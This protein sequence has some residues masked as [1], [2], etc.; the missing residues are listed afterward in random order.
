AAAAAATVCLIE[1][2]GSYGRAVGTGFLI[3]PSLVLTARHVVEILI[4][5]TAQHDEVR[6]WFDRKFLRN[7]KALNQGVHYGLADA[8]PLADDV[9]LDF[10][11]L[12]LDGEAGAGS[13]GWLRVP[14][15]PIVLTKGAPLIILQYPE[16]D[17]LKRALDM[18][19]IAGFSPDKRRILHQTN[20]RPG[21]SGAPCFDA[22]WKLVAMHCGVAAGAKGYNEAVIIEGIAARLRSDGILKDAE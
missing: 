17:P 5:G 8:K 1:I 14:A 10:A 6:V 12:R 21:S 19:S 16:G 22:H 18:R 15:P 20:T 11:V 3:A 9:N 13:R 2:S 4:D 7:G